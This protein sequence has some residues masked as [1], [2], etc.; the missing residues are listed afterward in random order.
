[1]KT[2]T[3]FL[4]LSAKELLDSPMSP[5]SIVLRTLRTKCEL[6]QG[7]FAAR[8]GYRQS[9]ISALECGSKL[10]KEVEL[11]RRIVHVLDLDDADEASLRDAFEVSRHF[12]LPPRGAPAAAYHLCAQ[13]SQVLPNLSPADV[14]ALSAVLEVFQRGNRTVTHA[15]RASEHAKETPM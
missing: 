9:Y 7:E 8:L 4:R 2:A 13:F 6:A 3:R 15:S 11:I 5:F 14:K 1:M 12:S 10:P